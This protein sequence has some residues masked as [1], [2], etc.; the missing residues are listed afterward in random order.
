MKIKH[1]LVLMIVLVMPAQCSATPKS[2][3]LWRQLAEGLQYAA[4]SFEVVEGQRTTISAFR[5]DPAKYE[6]DVTVAEN[7]IKGT[8][9]AEMAKARGAMIAI[10]GGFF[11]PEHTSIGLIIKNGRQLKPLHNTSWWSVFSIAGDKPSISAPSQFQY[12]GNISMA[13]QVGPRLTIAGATPKLKEGISARSAVGIDRRSRVILLVTSGHGISLKELAKRMGGS[14]F[15]GGFDCPDSMALDG[16]SSTQIYAK[17]GEFELDQ[18]GLARV[19]NGI[20]VLP[21]K[22]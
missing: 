1:L 21:K 20:V 19:T 17:V 3:Y 22:P 15:H 2:P 13:L 16:G 6:L 18:P 12:A 14:M 4:Y 8:T 5:I 9:A 10:N 7:E 11:T